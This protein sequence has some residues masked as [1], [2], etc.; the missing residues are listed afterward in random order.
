M[1]SWRGVVSKYE[2]QFY[3]NQPK[4]QWHLR[5][6]SVRGKMLIDNQSTSTAGGTS[7]I[8]GTSDCVASE[9][10]HTGYLSILYK[11]SSLSTA[12]TE[13]PA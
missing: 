11:P 12:S 6:T 5:Q 9:S 8:S 10:S 3:L 7:G 13:I 4:Y 1:G 2:V